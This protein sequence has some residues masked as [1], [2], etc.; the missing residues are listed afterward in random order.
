VDA[1]ACKTLQLA[2]LVACL[3]E[4]GLLPRLTALRFA[5]QRLAGPVRRRAAAARHG[6]R[7]RLP[8]PAAAAAL[9]GGSSAAQLRL[10]GADGGGRR[11]CCCA[12]L[13]SRAQRGSCSYSSATAPAARACAT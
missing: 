4:A 2:V 11:A 10:R 1:S 5:C 8:R 3:R 6:V 13:G 7:S 9:M 12:Y